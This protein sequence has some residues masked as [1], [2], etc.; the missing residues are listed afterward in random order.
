M[1]GEGTHPILRS[2]RR[3]A[4]ESEIRRLTDGELVRRFVRQRDEAAFE[5]LVHRHAGM[6]WHVCN[7]LVWDSHAAEDAFQATFLVFVRRARSIGRP[8]LVGNWLYGVA[9]R[10]AR[11]ARQTL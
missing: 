6:V 4:A 5:V 10:V 9:S 2:I 8:D 3:L 7:Q 1:A 11:R